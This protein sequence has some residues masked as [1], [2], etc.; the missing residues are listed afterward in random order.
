M[1]PKLSA[2]KL[3]LAAV[4]TGEPGSSAGSW[5]RPRPNRTTLPKMDPNT[6]RALTGLIVVAA[7]LVLIWALQ[8]GAFTLPE[9]AGGWIFE[10]QALIAGILAAAAAAGTIYFLRRQIS[11]TRCMV[12]E[13]IE[14]DDRRARRAEVEAREAV[15]DEISRTL[16]DFNVYW[17]AV[18][19][20]LDH[21]QR[22]TGD[23]PI[24]RMP[25][26][27]L[28]NPERL[29]ELDAFIGDLALG[30][31]L[32]CRAVV[33]W[34]RIV[35]RERDARVEQLFAFPIPHEKRLHRLI[36]L[37][38]ALSH[39][40]EAC[41]RAEPRLAAIFAGRRK[42]DVDWRP[43]HESMAKV[44]DHFERDHPLPPV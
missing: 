26:E 10:Y 13:Q 32:R 27:A 16:G 18:S 42:R 22:G 37:E 23:H 9:N 3:V 35:L 33:Q 38:I 1:A 40:E 25:G 2:D 29:E 41:R 30:D 34:M 43:M 39:L 21:L 6:R 17:R 14:A 7:P 31:R 44:L 28:P 8:W 36:H 11:E 4:A 19:L 12:R 24:D 20:G 15:L 5:Y